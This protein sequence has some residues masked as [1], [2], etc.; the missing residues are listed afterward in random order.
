VIRTPTGHDAGILAGVGA[1][2]TVVEEP[3]R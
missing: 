1:L 2:V 3:A